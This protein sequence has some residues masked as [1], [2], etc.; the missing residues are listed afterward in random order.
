MI[1][2]DVHPTLASV[3]L[4]MTNIQPIYSVQLKIAVSVCY[5]VVDVESINDYFDN[6]KNEEDLRSEEDER[7]IA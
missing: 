5:V 2:D 6:D 7:V 3:P 1:W 4:H